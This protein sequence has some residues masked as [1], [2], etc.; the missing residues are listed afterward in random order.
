MNILKYTIPTSAL[1]IS[2]LFQ[3]THLPAMQP[4]LFF[5]FR[6]VPADCSQSDHSR[7]FVIEV[8]SENDKSPIAH[9][10]FGF[11]EPHTPATIHSLFVKPHYQKKGIGSSLFLD[12]VALLKK[13]KIKRIEWLADGSV[14][15]YKKF[16]AETFNHP[17]YP[18]D[19][20]PQLNSAWMRYN[21]HN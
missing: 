17:D 13:N 11:D 14:S 6:A 10:A 3:I 20:M 15:F 5:Q 9:I 2:F 12:C 7:N 8:S 16:G 1:V 21:L 18:H 19:Y 4:P